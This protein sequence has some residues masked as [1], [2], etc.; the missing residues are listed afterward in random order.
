MT[1]GLNSH[2]LEPEGAAIARLGK[3]APTE[4]G[5]HA[6]IK[7][8]QEAVFFYIFHARII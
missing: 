2:I 4:T 7:E 1:R 8:P 5:M 3:Y 6:I